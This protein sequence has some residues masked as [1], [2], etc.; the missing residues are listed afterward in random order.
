MQAEY[1]TSY[2]SCHGQKVKSVGEVFPDVRISVLSK[3]FVVKAIDLSDLPTLMVASQNCDAI[4]V[5]DF[6]S[7]KKS[8]CL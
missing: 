2:N 8:N 4:P 5:S 7:Y 3:T 1:T 6:Q